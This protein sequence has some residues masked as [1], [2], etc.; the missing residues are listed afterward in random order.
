MSS[1]L[2]LWGELILGSIPD[3]VLRY[4]VEHNA[5]LARRIQFFP[6]KDYDKEDCIEVPGWLRKMGRLPGK[7]CTRKEWL[8]IVGSDVN[9]VMPSLTCLYTV[10]L[11][12]VNTSMTCLLTPR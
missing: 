9:E 2:R 1:R 11:Y 3:K 6:P 7:F 12:S 4:D 10:F 5:H 8:P